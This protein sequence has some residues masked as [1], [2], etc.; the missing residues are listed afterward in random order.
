[1]DI[2]FLPRHP[3]VHQVRFC[4]KDINATMHW[5]KGA[6][7]FVPSCGDSCCCQC[8]FL[9]MLVRLGKLCL[10]ACLLPEIFPHP[11]ALSHVSLKSPECFMW[12]FSGSC[13][14]SPTLTAPTPAT[15]W[16]GVCAGLNLHRP[17]HLYTSAPSYLCLTPKNL[18]GRFGS[19]HTLL[20]LP[21]HSV[22]APALPWSHQGRSECS[23]GVREPRPSTKEAVRK[24][25]TGL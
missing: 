12:A 22:P 8:P 13:S 1:M 9:Q 25:G 11:P 6:L 23:R 21:A 15:P 17:S 18:T 7:F 3:T 4:C 5:P 19:N 16:H 10:L 14:S 2:R 20:R 24:H